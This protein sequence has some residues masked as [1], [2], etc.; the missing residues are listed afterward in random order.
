MWFPATLTFGWYVTLFCSLSPDHGPFAAG[1]A[2]LVWLYITSFS[3]LIG[4]GTE[5]VSLSSVRPDQ[6]AQVELPT[7]IPSHP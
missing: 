6:D 3:A 5:S 2:T 4:A 7:T 1:I